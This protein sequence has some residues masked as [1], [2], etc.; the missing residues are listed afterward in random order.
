MKNSEDNRDNS[1]GEADGKDMLEASLL[2]SLFFLQ[3]EAIKM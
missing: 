3:E 2:V 1:S